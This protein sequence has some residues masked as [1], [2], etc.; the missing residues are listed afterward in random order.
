MSH[1]SIPVLILIRYVEIPKCRI[2]D[3]SKSGRSPKITVHFIMH[4]QAVVKTFESCEGSQSQLFLLFQ[5][6]ISK[7]Y[8]RRLKLT[9]AQL[10]EHKKTK[11]STYLGIGG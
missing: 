5:L 7:I 2:T 8:F 11:L 9:Q 3:G 4:S 10:G 6:G 1:F